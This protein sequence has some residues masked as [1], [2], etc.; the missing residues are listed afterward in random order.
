[1]THEEPSV[2]ID[3]L[4]GELK[5]IERRAAGAHLE[6]AF[7]GTVFSGRE[8][9]VLSFRLRPEIVTAG[10]GTPATARSPRGPD[11]I[12]LRCDAGDDFTLD[13]ARAWFELAWRLAGGEPAR[14]DPDNLEPHE[15]D[16]D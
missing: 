12:A 8:G 2:A 16:E 14:V 5:G 1:M 11:W 6:F 7:N 15:D 4:A 3:R 13:R 9:S 10:L